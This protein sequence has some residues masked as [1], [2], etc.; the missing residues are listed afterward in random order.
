MESSRPQLGLNGLNFFSAAMQ[1]AF[2]PF[3]SVYLTEREWTQGNIGFVLSIGTAA[4]MAFQLPAGWIVDNIHLKRLSTA[5]ALLILANSALMIIASPTWGMVLASQVLHG[6]ASCMITPAIAALTMVLCGHASYSERLGI[7]GRYASLGGACAAGLLGFFAHYFSQR[8]VFIVGAS[9]VV[10]AL[11]SLLLI[12]NSDR[13]P[14]ADEHPAVLHPRELKRRDHRA[15]H[16]FLETPLHTFAGCV[17]LFHLANAAMLPLALNELAKRI[18]HS[19]FVVSFAIMVPQAV[20][21]LCSPLAGR[22][23]EQVGRR[24]ILLLGFA[25]VPL[26]ALL[27]VTQPDAIPLVLIE[28]LDGVSATVFGLAMPLVAADVTRRS[29]YM[30]LAIG[31]LGLAAGIGATA[32]T[33]LA[34]WA[35]DA[36]GVQ[37]AFLLL[38]LAGAAA[39]LSVWFLMPETRPAK[40]VRQT[41]A[42]VPA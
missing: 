2:G 13:V 38:A 33:T 32:S 26:R 28:L 10:P 30:N 5:L 20:A 3:F 8:A 23:A 6:F 29:G 19:G 41:P 17:V 11:L 37:A 42:M 4:A 12:R 36:L 27:F 22:L 16:I 35:A 14:E 1:T 21:V 15:W 25:A 24:P 40:P 7:N 9:F 31:S 39:V 18:G 34:G